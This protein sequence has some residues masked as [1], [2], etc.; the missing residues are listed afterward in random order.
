[1][2]RRI[3][4]LGT[5]L[6]TAM[7]GIDAVQR[8]DVTGKIVDVQERT[9]D[10]VLLYQVNTPIMTEDP[11]VTISVDVNGI[12]YKGELLPRNHQEVFS[13]IWK[14]RE[15]VQLRLDKHFMYLRREDGSEV[16]FLVIGKAR[17]QS[18]REFH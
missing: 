2:K 5:V 7:T 18:A 9:R 1:M 17:P 4:L 8:D 15:T 10:R 14:A 3:L 12:V 13:D 11:Y 16:K 6:L